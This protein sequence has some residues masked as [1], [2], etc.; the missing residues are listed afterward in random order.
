MPSSAHISRRDHIKWGSSPATE[1]TST[2]VL[3]TKSGWYVDVRVLLSTSSEPDVSIS[4]A[5]DDHTLFAETSKDGSFG[6]E[7]LDWAFAGQAL[8]TPGEKGGPSH[9]TW[10]HWVDSKTTLEEPPLSDQGDMFPQPDGRTLEK[11]RMANPATG[12]EEDYE[13]LWRDQTIEKPSSWSEGRFSCV[14]LKHDGKGV[15]GS[16][17]RLGRY[18]QGV[19]RIDDDFTAERWLFVDGE[20]EFENGQGW[21]LLA[22]V[23]KGKVGCEAL[24]GENDDGIVAT[25]HLHSGGREWVVSEVDDVW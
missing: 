5:K 24:I 15:K 6:V 18:C 14:V 1:P 22:R 20:K 21:K 12:V 16:V 9:S 3:T 4:P 8:S 25:K 19:L 17:V 10:E 7:R 2:L 23:G 13:E 11:G